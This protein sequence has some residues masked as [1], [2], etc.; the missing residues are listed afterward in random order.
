MSDEVDSTGLVLIHQDGDPGPETEFDQLQVSWDW[1]VRH[2]SD[3]AAIPVVG[4]I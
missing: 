3:R 2:G 1:G 4:V